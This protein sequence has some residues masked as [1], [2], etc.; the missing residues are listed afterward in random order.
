MELDFDRELSIDSGTEH[1]ASTSSGYSP[2]PATSSPTPQSS[3]PQPPAAPTP[4]KAK[5]ILRNTNSRATLRQEYGN[6]NSMIYQELS[7][8]DSLPPVSP[9]N[10]L[11][12]SEGHIGIY[13][14][15]I[16]EDPYVD[17]RPEPVAFPE[18][19]PSNNQAYASTYKTPYQ[20]GI[21]RPYRRLRNPPPPPITGNLTRSL[22]HR[23]KH[24][25]EVIVT[26]ITFTDDPTRDSYEAFLDRV[27]SAGTSNK[28]NRDLVL[29]MLVVN[30]DNGTS[31]QDAS[32]HV[33]KHGLATRIDSAQHWRDA[34]RTMR[35]H[36]WLNQGWTVWWWEYKGN[37]PVGVYF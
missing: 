9:S 31:L 33:G 2:P 13:P 12:S 28:V 8:N 22:V 25:D 29:G 21:I 26:E 36:R 30:W 5:I 11:Q 23:M 34:V 24:S 14:F 17:D 7:R 6:E 15:P 35:Q 18:V 10:I 3:F 1:T 19:F 20:R 27:T 37:Q 16:Y 4:P 32:V